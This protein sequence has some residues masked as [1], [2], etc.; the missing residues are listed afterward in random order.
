MNSILIG[1]IVNVHGIK[2]EVKIYTYTDDIKNLSKLKK[3]YFD[4]N[5]QDEHKVLS[6]KIQ[7]N[8][9]IVKFEG[10]DDVDVANK[11]RDTDVYTKKEEIKQKD[12]YYIE[13]LIS[14][15]VIKLEDE[16]LIGKV[17]Y[18]FSTGANDVLEI[19]LVDGKKVY[20]PMIKDVIKN[21]DIENK[22]IFVSVM[23]GL[24]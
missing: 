6:S 21:V 15:E 7:N 19:D 9:L 17:A 13:D 16:S 23:E 14:C 4:K 8:M 3:M 5:M 22:K 1:K 11:L 2:G 10:I 12:T 24:M 18:V 20:F